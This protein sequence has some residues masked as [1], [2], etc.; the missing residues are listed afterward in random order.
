VSDKKERQ[1]AIRQ[2]VWNA[3]VNGLNKTGP[4]DPEL[5]DF[6]EHLRFQGYHITKIKGAKSGN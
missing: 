3:V 4:M 5:D 1:E 6:I 2:A